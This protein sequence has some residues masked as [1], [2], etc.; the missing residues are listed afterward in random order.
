MSGQILKKVDGTELTEKDMV[1][2]TLKL[3]L[4]YNPD[5][6]EKSDSCNSNDEKEVDNE[7]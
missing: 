3:L 5:E 7:K 1:L 2:A 4:H 6:A